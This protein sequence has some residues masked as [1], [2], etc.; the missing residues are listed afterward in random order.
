MKLKFGV[1]ETISN[2]MAGMSGIYIIPTIE[3]T[4]CDKIL[5]ISLTFLKWN[6]FMIFNSESEEKK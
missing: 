6:C 2:G 5:C 4:K 3:I 1:Q